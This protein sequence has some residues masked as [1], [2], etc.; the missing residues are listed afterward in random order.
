LFILTLFLSACRLENIALEVLKPA[1]QTLPSHINNIVV[2]NRAKLDDEAFAESNRGNIIAK[3]KKFND[4]A[5]EEAVWTAGEK[6]AGFD[7]L[8]VLVADTI[9][10]APKK[11]DIPIRMN[12]SQIEFYQTLYKADAVL[13]LEGFRADVQS[14]GTVTTVLETD[15]MGFTFEVPY[16]RER[17]N[18]RVEGLWRLYDLKNDT[19]I[20]QNK[21]NA[22]RSFLGEGFTQ[23]ESF[24][25]LPSKGKSILMVS[26]ETGEKIVEPI[27]PYWSPIMRKLYVNYNDKFIDAFALAYVGEW[28]E[29][30]QIWETMENNGKKTHKKQA[31]YNITVA[32]EA[33]EFFDEALALNNQY[34][35]K[36]KDAVFK[37]RKK[38]LES[39][40]KEQRLLDQQFGVKN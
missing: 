4:I 9:D 19:V 12:K 26:A 29:A 27:L 8:F 10:I 5:M 16:F 17:R 35:K 11:E 13:A 25:N 14:N 39:R 40:I 24:E 18:V 31:S 34:Y 30:Y 21:I 36:Y 7:R 38:E 28:A 20:L 22:R 23:N 3:Y 6:L 15:D 32:M 37:K 2:V 1:E 33:L